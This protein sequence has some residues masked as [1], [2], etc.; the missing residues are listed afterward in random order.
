MKFVVLMDDKELK[1]LEVFDAF[2]VPLGEGRILTHANM[3]SQTILAECGI[4][5]ESEQVANAS[6]RTSGPVAQLLRKLK[7]AEEKYATLE[8][9]NQKLRAELHTSNAE[10]YRLKD[11]LVQQQLANNARVDRVLDMLASAS[12]KPG[13]PPQ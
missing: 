11:Q 3:F 13:Q 12:T 1:F 2:E 5:M 9:E 4:P 10:I 7:V 8:S 6:S